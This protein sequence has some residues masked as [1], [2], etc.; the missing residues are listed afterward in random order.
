MNLLNNSSSN[1]SA[2]PDFRSFSHKLTAAFGGQLGVF[3][4]GGVAQGFIAA[5]VL[6]PEGKGAF[7]L[8]VLIAG[9]IYTVFHGSL[10]VANSHYGGRCPAWRPAIVGNGLALALVAGTVLALSFWY[11]GESL[12]LRFYPEADMNLLK[13]VA[14]AIPL[15]LL[16]DYSN[17][18]LLGQNRVKQFSLMLVSRE[19]LFLMAM[20]ALAVL[21]KLTVS[22]SVTAWVAAL[23]VMAVISAFLSWAGAGRR[24]ELNVSILIRMLRFSFQAHVAN[25]TTFLRLHAEKFILLYFLDLRDFGYYSVSVLFLPLLYHLP[26]AASQALLPHVSSGGDQSGNELTPRI[27]RMVLWT[28]ALTGLVVAALAKTAIILIPGRNYLPALVPLL[29]LLPGTVVSILGR[30]LS[31]DLVGRGKP[32]YAMWI[33]LVV[34]AAKVATAWV[35]IPIMGLNGAALAASVTHGLN[36][37]LFLWAFYHESK[38]PFRDTLILKKSDLTEALKSIRRLKA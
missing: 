17:N 4:F 20:T 36:G 38:V 18:S 11:G 31:G 22:S 3:L 7:S 5:R 12:L 28:T 29:I 23:A 26:D 15:M 10:G 37:L 33:S 1:G 6:G 19:F 21:K 13:I 8:A 14:F 34:M 35:L 32:G 25:L 27:C 9:V 30:V 2:P 24:L 16:L